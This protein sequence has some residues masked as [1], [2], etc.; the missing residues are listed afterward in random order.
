VCGTV[1]SKLQLLPLAPLVPR[2]VCLSIAFG[3]GH[4]DADC[5]G[6]LTRA[7]SV[8]GPAGPLFCPI[9]SPFTSGEQ[10]RCTLRFGRARWL[11]LM[12]HPRGRCGTRTCL[13]TSSSPRGESTRARAVRASFSF[14]SQCNGGSWHAS[15]CLDATVVA[16]AASAGVWSAHSLSVE[17]MPMRER[18]TRL[19]A[20]RVPS[21][22]PILVPFVTVCHRLTSVNA[23][24]WS[25]A[26]V[27][28]DAASA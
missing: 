5:C 22:L 21:G 9:L 27:V 16:D 17:V 28:A 7:V 18:L 12:P 10:L 26:I 13:R 23:S 19:L 3:R 6:R 8:R 1:R 24:P 15:L 20:V 14:C 2:T 25:G 11:S 4:V